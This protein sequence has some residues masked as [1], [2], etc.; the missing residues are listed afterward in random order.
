MAANEHKNLTDINR[1]F[2]MGFENAN[3]DTI[4]TKDSGTSPTGTDGNLVWTDK[5]NIKTSTVSV[6]GYSTGDG[7][8]FKYRNQ[9]SDGQSPFEIATS[10]GSGTVGAA[11]I[12]VSNIFRTANHVAQ[13]DCKVMK[14]R[15]WV[16]GNTAAVITIAICKITPTDGSASDLTPVLIDEFTVTGAGNDVLKTVNQT[17][18]TAASVSAGDFIFPMIKG[19]G[20]QVIYCN[21]T[22]ELGYDN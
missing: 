4:L 13:D 15:G 3:N 18:I 20:S 16:T 9:I 22:L 8:N 19:G 10:Y 7:S 17:T 6:I 21:M 12:D 14:I 2:P 11:V 5:K 1:H